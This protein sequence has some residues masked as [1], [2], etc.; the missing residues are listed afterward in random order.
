MNFT[1]NYELITCNTEQTVDIFQQIQNSCFYCN[2]ADFSMHKPSRH[3]EHSLHKSS[4]NHILY[5]GC[6]ININSSA[7]FWIGHYMLTQQCG[8]A[9]LFFRTVSEQCFTSPPTQYRLYGRRFLQ[10]KRPNQQH[11]VTCRYTTKC[12]PVVQL[13]SHKTDFR[14]LQYNYWIL[15]KGIQCLQV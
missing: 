9:I 8:I 11:K 12:N 5:T 6:T 3:R 4:T 14:S 13:I 2:V 1:Q 7:I 10:V 15:T